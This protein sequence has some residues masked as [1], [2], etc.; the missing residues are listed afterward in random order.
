MWY[1]NLY[2]RFLCDMHIEDIREEFMAEFS[3]EEFVENLK[4]ANINY[5]MYYAQSH[6]GL[7]YYPTKTGVM[8]KALRGREDLMRRVETLCHDNGIKVIT[9]YSLIFNTREHDRH[10]EWRMITDN[11]QS[12]RERGNMPSDGLAFASKQMSRYGLCCPNNGDYTKFVL[13]QIDEILEYFDT[14]ALFFDM[15]FWPWPAT[16]FCDSCRERWAREVGGDI[17]NNPKAGTKEWLTLTHKRYEW[18]GEWTQMIYDYIKAKDPDMTVEYNLASMVAGSSSNGCGLEVNVASDYCGGDIYGDI[19]NH[20][21]VS[22]FYKNATK[23]PPFEFMISRC[24]PALRA[25][26][27]TK[28]VDELKTSVALTAAHHGASLV[29]DAIDPVGTLDSR[30]YDRIGEAYRFIEPYEP[31]FRGKMA[32]DV[33]VY[34]GIKSRLDPYAI[35][36]NSLDG[37]AGIAHSL[38]R[39]HIP[40]GVTCASYELEGYRALIAPLLLDTEAYENER[41]ESYVKN[42]GLLYLSGAGNKELTEKLTGGKIG[43]RL[44]EKRLYLAPAKDYEDSFLGFNAKYPLPY[45]GTGFEFE[46][47][48]DCEVIA[49]YTLPFT[50]SNAFEFTSIHSDPP[51]ISTEIPAIVTAKY[52]KGRVI[53][54]AMPLE[55]GETEEYGELLLSLI[56]RFDGLGE[57]SFKSDAP[58]NVEITLFESEGEKFIN[59]VVLCDGA[60][61][62]P[63][64]PF[65]V[66]V[67]CEKTPTGVT[68]LPEGT[69]VDFSYENGYARFETGKLSIF[70]MYRIA[71]D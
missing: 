48:K 44:D 67:K 46:A 41:F 39:G 54:S 15:P 38:I 11:G 50:P 53:W 21:F 71:L 13:A 42:G 16:C 68:L 36:F 7:C 40:F 1:S 12:R 28:T 43:Q 24:K 69:P 33:G 4:K 34:Y 5:A 63:V 14:D 8:H 31:Y 57:P 49:T 6:V 23:N 19:Y 32:E 65:E 9:Y 52:G 66:S 59:C 61:S 62:Y 51:G 29:I 27:L 70:D 64:S 2:R 47:G 35:K 25:H 17:P 10:P 60:R 26:T 45:D 37:N 56:D 18:M 55:C 3:P 30:V 58:N 22:K 20:S